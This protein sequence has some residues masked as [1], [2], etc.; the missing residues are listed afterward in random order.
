MRVAIH[1]RD[2]HSKSLHFIEKL[3][4]ILKSCGADIIISDKVKK[5]NDFGT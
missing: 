2:F 5:H 4:A 3:V 1:G